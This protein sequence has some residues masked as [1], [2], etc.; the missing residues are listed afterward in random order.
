[1]WANNIFKLFVCF[2]FCANRVTYNLSPGIGTRWPRGT[3]RCRSCDRV[4]R[5]RIPPMAA[6]YRRQLSVPSLRGRL[7][8][9]SESWKVNGHTTRCTGSVSVVLP[10]R[11]VSGWGLRK[12]RSAPPHG[13]GSGKAY[14]LCSLQRLTIYLG[15]LVYVNVWSRSKF[16][17]RVHLCKPSVY[18][19][20]L[21]CIN[22]VEGWL[23]SLTY[24]A[25]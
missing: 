6:V 16:H 20:T 10:L 18:H 24:V 11:L 3:E 15:L 9:T 14:S 8:T 19:G 25:Q 2:F 17:L 1:M 22:C 7:M 5:V 13:P 4:S 21:Y 23:C 12:R